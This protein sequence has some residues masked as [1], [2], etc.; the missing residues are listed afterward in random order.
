MKK[1]NWNS[2]IKVKLTDLGKDIYYHRYDHLNEELKCINANM[3]IEPTYP[4]VD[5]EGYT[6]FMLWYFMFLY[7]A[8]IHL[9]FPD[10]VETIDFF[11]E[12]EDLEEV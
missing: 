12:D 6:E 11:I 8:H 2:T 1:L 5:E 10:V 7:G 3:A 9:I 4:K